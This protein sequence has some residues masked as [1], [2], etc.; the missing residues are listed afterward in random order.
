M[1]SSA[2]QRNLLPAALQELQPIEAALAVA[3]ERSRGGLD[4][5]EAVPLPQQPP[6]DLSL[7]RGRP[8]RR[9]A[10]KGG[11]KEQFLSAVSAAAHTA[12]SAGKAASKFV[13]QEAL[14]AQCLLDY[15]VGG[16]VATAGSGHALWRIFTA[17]SK[18]EG[19][20]ATPAPPHTP[21]RL[22]PPAPR[23][24]RSPPREQP[25]VRGAPPRCVALVMDSL[26]RCPAPPAPCRLAAPCGQR[27][28]TGQ[29][30]AHADGGAAVRERG[31]L[32]G[33][34]ARHGSAWRREMVHY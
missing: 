26:C 14:G 30:G 6:G 8:P 17:R 34:A 5:T 24:R 16:Q 4:E 2:G 29:A 27:L 20:C 10:M 33:W 11:F 23:Q 18:K 7:A 1:R 13:Q 21:G 9:S 32:A 12:V 3:G 28:D 15:A 19:A 31:W 22:R 25:A